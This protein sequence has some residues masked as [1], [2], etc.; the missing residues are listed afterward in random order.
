MLYIGLYQPSFLTVLCSISSPHGTARS[1]ALKCILI[2][3]APFTW[4]AHQSLYSFHA[5]KTL[6]NL[7][8]T[9]LY[10]PSTT[11]P[12][13]TPW[14]SQ[15]G[16]RFVPC[17]LLLLSLLPFC[18]LAVPCL[19]SV[20]SEIWLMAE[21]PIQMPPPLCWKHSL[22]IPAG[23]KAPSEFLVYLVLL[24]MTPISCRLTL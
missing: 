20:H 14:S 16:S 2:K 7:T 22:T 11:T 17:A 19:P 21:C 13:S 18:L 6:H 10:L 23:S 1:I 9:Y 12:Y 3:T 4:I 5:F 15:I 8:S 24:S